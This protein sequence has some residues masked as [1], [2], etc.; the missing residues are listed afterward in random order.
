M[1]IYRWSSDWDSR[2]SRRR[3]NGKLAR[4]VNPT[5]Y[6]LVIR[7]PGASAAGKGDGAEIER[8]LFSATATECSRTRCYRQHQINFGNNADEIDWLNYGNKLLRSL[9]AKAAQ[10]A[11]DTVKIKPDFYEAWYARGLALM[12]RKIS[13]SN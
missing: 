9:E 11:F 1:V 7:S 6:S 13:R 10:E 5:G 2:S 12:R 4:N 3:F 8:R